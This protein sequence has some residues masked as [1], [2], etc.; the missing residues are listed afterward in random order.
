MSEKYYICD[1]KC[2]CNLDK[3]GKKNKYCYANGG[4]E[5]YCRHT[6]DINHAKYDKHEFYENEAGHYFEKERIK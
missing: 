6:R 3:N 5:A 4:E 1:G 2:K